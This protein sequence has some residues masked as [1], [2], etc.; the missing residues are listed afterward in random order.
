MCDTEIR[1]SEK[2]TSLIEQGIKEPKKK[3]ITMDENL[4]HYNDN[5][6]QRNQQETV[7][8]AGTQWGKKI[9]RI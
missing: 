8:H 6:I 7:K 1:N 9:W 2:R 5:R 4:G 3:K